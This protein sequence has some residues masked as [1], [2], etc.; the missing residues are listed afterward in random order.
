MATLPA[1]YI[2][3]RKVPIASSCGSLD[4]IVRSNTLVM[5]D[6]HHSLKSCLSI[7]LFLLI[8]IFEN[9]ITLLRIGEAV[10]ANEGPWVV[11]VR[12]CKVRTD[13]QMG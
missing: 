13:F 5:F 11:L 3:Q 8:F 10:E 6:P 7:F 12:N 4:F 2:P 1:G 9:K